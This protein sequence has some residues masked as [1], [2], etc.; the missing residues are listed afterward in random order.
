MEREI[1]ELKRRKKSN[2]RVNSERNEETGENEGGEG[3][4]GKTNAL[5]TFLIVSASHSSV[6][7]R[8]H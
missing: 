3:K 7:P 1:Y 4:N 2:C 6:P 5:L 8:L